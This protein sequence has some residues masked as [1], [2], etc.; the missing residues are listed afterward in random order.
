MSRRKYVDDFFFENYKKNDPEAKCRWML[1][2]LKSRAKQKG[3]AFDLDLN[4]LLLRWERG[5]CEVTGLRFD[6]AE[7]DGKQGVKKAFQPS[8][9]RK[10]SSKGYTKENCQ[11]VVYLYNAAKN[12]FTHEDVVKFCKAMLIA[13]S[14]KKIQNTSY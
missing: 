14:L 1:S 2:T 11:M 8:I 10:D 9:D 3:L 12:K 7:Y 4:W 13:E 6:F 5:I